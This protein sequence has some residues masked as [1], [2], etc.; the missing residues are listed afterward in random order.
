MSKNS[1]YY[2][3]VWGQL[4]FSLINW[5][6]LSYTN[7][8]TKLPISYYGAYNALALYV[9][10]AAYS[11]F[12]CRPWYAEKILEADWNQK[13]ADLI[14]REYKQTVVLDGKSVLWQSLD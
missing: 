11:P 2:Y 9:N 7:A 1:E 8:R 4:E 5:L 12:Y 14:A 13:E 6:M 3:T 10:H